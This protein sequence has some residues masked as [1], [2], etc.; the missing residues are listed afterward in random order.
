VTTLVFSLW[1]NNHVSKKYWMKFKKPEWAQ[2]ATTEI[3]Y[4]FHYWVY[5]FIAT[6]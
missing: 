4:W 1:E 5:L 3:A 6:N 2:V